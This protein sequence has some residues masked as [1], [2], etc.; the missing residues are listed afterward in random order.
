MPAAIHWSKAICKEPG[1]YPAWPTI[2]G[3]LL[4]RP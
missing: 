2:A 4:R 3:G 1:S